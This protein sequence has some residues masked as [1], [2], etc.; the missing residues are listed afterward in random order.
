MRVFILLLFCSM[1][2]LFAGA[3]DSVIFD[4]D[5]QKQFADSWKI[6]RA[7]VH[8][9]VSRFYITNSKGARDGK[10]LVIDCRKSSGIALIST[11]GLDLKKNPIMRWRWRVINP[12][13]LKNK[14]EPDD[15]AASIYVCDGNSFRQF[16]VSYRWEVLPEIG[17]TK[18][19]RYG[20][21]ALTVYGICLRN[22]FTPV[23]EWVE[24]ERDVAA[25][26][27]KMFKRDIMSRFAIGI[28]GNSQYSKSNTRVEIDYVEFHPRRK[29]K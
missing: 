17:S 11:S 13:I 16:T 19:L 7:A 1:L 26:F 21:G 9:P 6:R 15:Q 4:F 3:T 5:D 22:R 14:K 12:I 2:S 8:V 24:E 27:K 18:L 10:A 23:G 25:D 28:G 29:N 20:S